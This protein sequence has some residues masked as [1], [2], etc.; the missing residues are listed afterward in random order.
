MP[1]NRRYWNKL[2]TLNDESFSD[3]IKLTATKISS[4]MTSLNQL[5]DSKQKEHKVM[6]KVSLSVYF[7]KQEPVDIYGS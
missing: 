5:I 1:R 4:S 7:F 2:V 3:K 6:N